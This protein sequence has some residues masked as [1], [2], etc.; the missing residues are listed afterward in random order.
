MLNLHYNQNL[1]QTNHGLNF[2]SGIGAQVN[3]TVNKRNGFR[4]H[5]S[6]N[7]PINGAARNDSIPCNKHSGR[8]HFKFN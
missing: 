2:I 8:I 7:A 3:V 1:A 5:T 6:D 4:P